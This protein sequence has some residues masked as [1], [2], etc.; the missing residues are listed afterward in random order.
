MADT[1]R[2]RILVEAE[3]KKALQNLKSTQKAGEETGNKFSKITKRIKS[4]WLALTA[5]MGTS[6]FA[7][8]KLFD[9][10]KEFA[11]FET[12][13]NA[14]R[15]S[16]GKSADEVINKL[17]E[18]SGG[19]IS[20]A[21]LVETA[22]RTMALNVTQDL[23]KMAEMLEVARFRAKIM[24]TDTE[25]AFSDMATGIGRMSP[26]ILDNLGF[27]TK[28]WA[29]EAKAA[30]VAYDQQFLLNKILEQG[31]E[32][33]KLAGDI[34]ED[35]TDRLQK[36][37]ASL[38]NL[39]LK[40]G[41]A[42]IPAL[43]LV[44]DK[45]QPVVDWM[46][47]LD[48]KT[49]ALTAALV[50]AV[51]LVGA[52]GLALGPIAGVVAGVAAAFGVATI[53]MKNFG[54]AEE[55]LADIQDKIKKKAREFNEIQKE[56]VFRKQKRL[57]KIAKEIEELKK[58][59]DITEQL[60]QKQKD[61]EEQMDAANKKREAAQKAMK[62]KDQQDKIKALNEEMDIWDKIAGSITG[63]NKKLIQNGNISDSVFK[64]IKSVAGGMQVA[65]S[66]A[67]EM[68]GTFIQFVQ[69]SAQQ[70]IDMLTAQKEQRIAIIDA[71]L[72]AKLE[73][74]GLK[75]ETVVERLQRELDE[76]VL[77][78]DRVAITEAENA[79]KKA[80]IEEQYLNMKSQAEK[81]YE[82]RVLDIKKDAFEKEK[83]LKMIQII[84]AGALA[85][86][87][88]FAQLGPIGGAIATVAIAIAQ[89]A[90]LAVVA[91]QKFP[92]YAKGTDFA[93]GGPSLVGEKG[94]EI[95]NLPQGAQVVPNDITRMLLDRERSVNNTSNNT[96][97]S[98]NITVKADDP[99]DF[100]NKMKRMYGVKIFS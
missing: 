31:K 7:V 54:T 1:N 42:V 83:K 21:K 60:I 56:G 81:E 26:L 16:F 58:E 18:V 80:E 14:M 75:E 27:I 13:A 25:E 55:R 38:D 44:L 76:A 74:E 30:G 94:P 4:S 19:T 23:D 50:V 20:N 63:L 34:S 70:E 66:Q 46:T 28:G 90:Q 8:K 15:L 89:T 11:R 61:L 71:E 57:E 36:F 59:R 98:Y 2:I 43:N 99:I 62:L 41:E 47:G 52:F 51:P 49:I 77:T 9:F 87:Q 85:S 45:I 65:I 97:N 35:S 5:A 3:V 29:E 64:K 40:I 88:A 22:N 82:R 92:A 69:Q 100:I 10:S 95:V 37:N 68:L 17:K 72:Q 78:G 79:V 24:G 96:N 33:M 32:Q 12:S 84:I 48:K 86:M 6:I 91:S 39:A 93:S 73:A 67:Q 53:A